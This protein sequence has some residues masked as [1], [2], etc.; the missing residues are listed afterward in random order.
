MENNIQNKSNKN[1]ANT[2]Y[3]RN[4]ILFLMLIVTVLLLI[5]FIFFLIEKIIFIILTKITFTK[6]ILLPIQIILHLLL[7]RYIIIQVAFAGQNTLVLRS[8]LLNL[9]KIQATHIYKKLKSLHDSLSI[10]NDIR[11]LASSIKELSEIKKQIGIIQTIINYSL[12]ILSRMK[13]KFNS[14]TTD[15]DIFYN[16]ILSLN[17]SI[18]N[19]NLL[20]FLNNTIDTIKKYGKESLSDVPDEDKNKIVSDLSDRNLNIQKILMLCHMLMEQIEDYIGEKYSCLNIRYIRNYF[21][22]K[23][24][25]KIN[26]K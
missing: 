1:N 26:V 21:N 25:A 14:L 12:D 17:D 3:K 23:L 15:Q 13:N 6:F 9:G 22:N 2:F 10:L 11:G 4:P 24:F 19:G 18:N 7:L 20:S 8:M 16:N 5:L